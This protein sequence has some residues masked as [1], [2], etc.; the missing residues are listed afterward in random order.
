MK[1]VIKKKRKIYDV[2]WYCNGFC[3]RTT[4][5]CDWETVKECRRIARLLGEKIEYELD[6]IEVDTYTL[7]NIKLKERSKI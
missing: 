5:G 7:C 4:R 3:Y 6:H 1:K 2:N